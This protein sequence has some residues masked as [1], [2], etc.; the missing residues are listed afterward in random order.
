VSTLRVRLTGTVEIALPPEQAF[1]MFTPS[2]ERTWSHGW[3]PRF[4]SPA[5]DETEPGTVFQTD[6]GGREST[7]IVTRC[8]HGQSIQ[9]VT[10]T[11]GERCGIVTVACEPSA[12]GTKA[13]V[14][15][16]FTALSHAAEAELGRF[17]MGFP[18]FLGHWESSIARAMN[19]ARRQAD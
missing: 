1:T 16:D 19:A 7:W 9:Y 2:G 14:S 12:N 6:H 13:T 5:A 8:D 15:Y 4:P 10:T 11:A 18:S 17:A 3:D